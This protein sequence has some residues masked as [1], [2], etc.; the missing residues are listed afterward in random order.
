[1]FYNVGRCRHFNQEILEYVKETAVHLNYDLMKLDDVMKDEIIEICAK[2][3][4]YQARDPIT[5]KPTG[6]YIN[7][8]SKS[9]FFYEHNFVLPM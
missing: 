9:F 8:F 2:D 4:S 6:K 7:S 5:L 3:I 1:M